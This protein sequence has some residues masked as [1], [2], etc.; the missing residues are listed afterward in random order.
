MGCGMDEWMKE[1]E[2]LDSLNSPSGGFNKEADGGFPPLFY[3]QTGLVDWRSCS[4]F[5]WIYTE[6]WVWKFLV[7]WKELELTSCSWT[8]RNNNA[9]FTEYLPSAQCIYPHHNHAL[10]ISLTHAG[11]THFNGI[12]SYHADSKWSNSIVCVLLFI[13]VNY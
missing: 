1:L 6:V 5:R 9:T 8:W 7:K 11:S 4:L 2:W 13:K 12:I 3:G 10:P